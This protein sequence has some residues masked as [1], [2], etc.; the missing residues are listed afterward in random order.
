[1][2]DATEAA[3]ADTWDVRSS[4]RLTQGTRRSANRAL[5]NAASICVLHI[6]TTLQET[7]QNAQ[8]LQT[9]FTDLDFAAKRA[10]DQDAHAP[11][12]TIK[13]RRVRI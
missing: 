1:M 7:K 13:D 4:V 11:K 8:F 6:A 12:N 10:R 9:R 5:L 3:A 2:A